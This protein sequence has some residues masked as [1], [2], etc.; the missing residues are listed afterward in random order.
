MSSKCFGSCVF[1]P[2]LVVM[3]SG[4]IAV[5]SLSDTKSLSV[6]DILEINSSV[7]KAGFNLSTDTTFSA[8]PIWMVNDFSDL[9]MTGKG[10]S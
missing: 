9:V 4:A 8:P 7:V 1:L 6:F 10:P 5:S 2:A 3:G